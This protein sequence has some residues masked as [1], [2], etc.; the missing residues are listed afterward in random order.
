MNIKKINKVNHVEKAL[1]ISL[2]VVVMIALLFIG[3]AAPA[4]AAGA[5]QISGIGHVPKEGECN[6][7]VTNEAGQPYDFSTRMEGDLVGCQY[8]FVTSYECSPS[9]TYREEGTEIYV[10]DGPYGQG[11]FSTTY[12]FRAK[13]EG[14]SP[15]GEFVGA[16]LFGFCQ[17]PIVAG[18]G[19]GDYEGVKGRIHFKDDVAAG[20][21]PYTGHLKW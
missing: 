7:N 12:F 17:H 8:V 21:F 16:E 11:T 9:G 10:I 5:I 14:C 13:F 20:N 18:S 15:D 6:D 3:F 2:A 19:T 4:H 1:R